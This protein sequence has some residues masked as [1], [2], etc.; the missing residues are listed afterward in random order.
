MSRPFILYFLKAALGAVSTSQLQHLQHSLGCSFSCAALRHIPSVLNRTKV[1]LVPSIDHHIALQIADD[2]LYIIALSMHCFVTVTEY[3]PCKQS[4]ADPKHL[5]HRRTPFCCLSQL[6]RQKLQIHCL[7]AL[8]PASGC[9]LSLQY[10]DCCRRT[11]PAR[12]WTVSA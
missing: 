10:P 5:I 3:F 1:G 11:S 2:V 9:G 12:V 7:A 8:S 6:Q 4:P